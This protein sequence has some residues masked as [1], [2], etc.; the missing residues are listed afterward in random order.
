LC[1]WPTCSRKDPDSC[2]RHGCLYTYHVVASLVLASS[3]PRRA[4]LLSESGFHFEVAKPL[5]A[6]K[7][8][9]S[10]TLRELTLWNAIRKGMSI[11]QTRPDTVVLAADTLVALGDQIIGKPADRSEAA[12]ML[13]RLSGRTHK[14]CSAVAIYQHTSGRS[15]VFHDV[16]HVRF[17]QLSN[18]TIE[19]YLAKVSPLDKAGAYAAQGNGA[20]IIAKIDGSFT[21]VVGLPMEKTVGA[22]AKFGIQPKS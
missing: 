6:E 8:D 13:R 2:S 4:A 1:G 22:L 5:L 17:R 11:A 9:A 7:F 3:S 16:S 15:A 20:E 19:N 14:V 12:R 10:L 18:E 21:N